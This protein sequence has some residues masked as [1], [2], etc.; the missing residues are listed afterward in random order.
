MNNGKFLGERNGCDR[1]FFFLKLERTLHRNTLFN[2]CLKKGT[3]SIFPLFIF[4]LKSH[5]RVSRESVGRDSDMSG[6]RCAERP[7]SNIIL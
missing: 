2:F 3:K 1:L 5:T 6:E 4:T 7:G